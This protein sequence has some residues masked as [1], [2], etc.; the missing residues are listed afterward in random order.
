M[1]DPKI[2]REK[3]LQR[4]QVESLNEMQ[5]AAIAAEEDGGDLILLSPT[6][7]GKTLAFLLPIV[8]QLD[9]EVDHIQAVII[10]PSR[11]L[12]LQIESVLR[13]MST[14]FK[15]NICYGGHPMRI[16]KKSLQHPPAVLIGTPG[17]IADH[18]QRE[19][20]DVG[21]TSFLVLDEF[22]KTLEYGFHK[23]MTFIMENLYNVRRKVLTSA[24]AAIQVP[25]FV[26]LQNK[27]KL[28]FLSE[29]K[30]P[31][32]LTLKTVI[33]PE[34]DKLGTLYKL[35]CR[36]GDESMLIFCNH[37]EAV[38]RVSHFLSTKDIVQDYFHGGLEQLDRERV[39]IKFRNGSLKIL[40]TTDLA[41]RGLDIP[42]IR[43][44]IHYHTP[45]R[46][47]PFIHRN[48]RTARMDARGKAF[49]IMHSEEPMP[50]YIR[51]PPGI[52]K[53]DDNNTPRP[54]PQW[55][56]LY[57]G[58]GKKD[59]VNKIDIVGFLSKKGLLEKGDI[60]LIEVKDFFSFV[61]INRKKIHNM[62]KLVSKHKIKGKKAKIE[63]AK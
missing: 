45:T 23:E 43:Y 11:E 58:K 5:E 10:A 34:R 47:D 54:K 9:P 55:R 63:I 24:T 59:K 36:L 60:G 17:R 6:G 44:V 42:E 53:L 35:I 19:N 32:G 48:G 12:A 21:K 26:V 61:A 7:S 14:G 40:V 51:T 28:N 27:K 4:M 57:I 1:Q 22:D 13:N 50:D 16:E 8:A 41:S 3:I 31:K 30:K 18:I 62:I 29:A 20:I 52:F 49:M 56:T 25:D 33:S 39:L 38:E 37:R 2:L 46:E 15:V